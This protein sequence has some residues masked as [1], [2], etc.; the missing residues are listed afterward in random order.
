MRRVTAARD[1]FFNWG[2][3]LMRKGSLSALCGAAALVFVLSLLAALIPL[4]Q[5]IAQNVFC[6]GFPLA[7]F[8]VR[9]DTASTSLNLLPLIFDIYLGY[10]LCRLLAKI[11]GRLGG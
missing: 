9:M 1:A 7:F 5:E 11:A 2:M 10:L 4:T 8:T 6:F 3:G